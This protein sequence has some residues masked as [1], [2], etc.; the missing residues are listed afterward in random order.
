MCFISKTDCSSLIKFA[1]PYRK[2]GLEEEEEKPQL[3]FCVCVF[4]YSSYR[5]T[6]RDEAREIAK[7]DH[8]G[9]NKSK[10]HLFL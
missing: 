2:V 1:S 3:F 7:V 6:E 4:F 10:Y 8:S 5:E 9:K